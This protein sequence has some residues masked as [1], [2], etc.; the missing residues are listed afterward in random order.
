MNKNLKKVLLGTGLLVGAGG[1]TV[2]LLDQNKVVHGQH[3]K[4]VTKGSDGGVFITS[5]N[6]GDTFVFKTA[7]NPF[8]YC[9][10]GGV[11]GTAKDSITLMNEGGRV[12]FTSGIT[13]ENSNYVCINGTGDSYY[14]Y[15]FLLANG[16]TVPAVI[17]GLSSY[18]NWHNCEITNYGKGQG[19]FWDKTEV[20]DAQAQG[21][22]KVNN[23]LYPNGM[24]HHNIYH[25]YFH[26]SGGDLYLGSTN[27]GNR[28]ALNCNG[29][30]TYPQVMRMGDI[31]LYDNII[32]SLGR[33]VQ[34][35]NCDTLGGSIHDNIITHIG[36]EYNSSQGGVWFGGNSK[37][38]KFYNNKIKD[39][40]LY[41]F[42]SYAVG[43][44][45]V[46]NNTFD[47]AGYFD[48]THKNPQGIPSTFFSIGQP[49]N[50]II[51]NNT[52][53]LNSANPS[54][55]W[56]FYGS[57][58]WS[59]NN[60]FCNNTGFVGADGLIYTCTEGNIPICDTTYYTY[61]SIIK[62]QYDSNYIKK[63]KA[64]ST[65]V[66]SFKVFNSDSLNIVANY[67]YIYHKNKDSIYTK[68][69]IKDSTIKKTKITV[70][71]N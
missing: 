9:Y 17:K 2:A 61:D 12:L 15:G 68:K 42:G 37:N 24:Y 65:V 10:V 29:K 38:L 47:S 62:I 57:K 55:G 59:T 54:T 33:S 35:S 7:D 40:W 14:E 27:V 51:K 20:V 3:Y 16:N 25:N 18:I 11:N 21:C 44:V 56:A 6:P 13:V 63:S 52:T 41:N 30:T 71:C 48:A 66:V 28:D 19:I 36:Y 53:G 8:T 32:D 4:Y 58:Q 60:I 23:Y 1:V 39:T 26:G 22:D 49:T 69:A 64:D 34:L 70:N 31:N 5:A 67:R 43:T 46:Y 45:E 50:F